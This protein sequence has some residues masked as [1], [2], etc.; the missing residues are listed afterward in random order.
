MQTNDYYLLPLCLKLV[1]KFNGDPKSFVLFA[2]ILLLLYKFLW[3]NLVTL[4]KETIELQSS[5]EW[6]QNFADALLEFAVI[7]LSETTS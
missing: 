2:V 7:K 6:L 3:I 4:G 1:E 5:D